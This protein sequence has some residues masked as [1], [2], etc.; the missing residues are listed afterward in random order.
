M[1]AVTLTQPSLVTATPA[2]ARTHA[3]IVVA[4]TLRLA[5]THA[6]V[7]V[8]AQAT[9]AVVTLARTVTPRT[10]SVV[11]RRGGGDILTATL[12][13]NVTFAATHGDVTHVDAAV[14]NK[15]TIDRLKS[16]STQY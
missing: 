4:R 7:T 8:A 15:N 3:R 11:R 12:C 16:L 1:T 9:P 14:Q 13:T 6:V 2:V 10:V 5:M